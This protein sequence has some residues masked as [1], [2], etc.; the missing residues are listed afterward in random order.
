L[1]FEVD[2]HC[3]TIAS[4]HAY[5]TVLEYVQIAAEKGLKMIAITDH[6][7]AMN[8]APHRYYFGNIKVIPRKIRE[9]YI[10]RGV[11]ANIM[12]FNGSLDLT[13][14]YLNNLDIV[15]AGFHA[16]CFQSGSVEDNTRAAISAIKNPYVDIIVHPGNPEFPIN[17]E[18]VVEAAKENNV[19]IE[20][21]NSSFNLSRKGSAENCLL[22]AKKAAELGAT[23]SLGSDSHICFDVGNFTKA[24]EIIK[25]AGIRQENILNTSVDKVVNFLKSKGRDIV[26]DIKRETKL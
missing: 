18:K 7:P 16:N 12:D 1:I 10:L 13:E 2:T 21:N 14:Y 6:G 22:I 11:E 23:I 4:G 24:R 26:P 20:I 9:V 8:G 19:C 15:L 3:H 5:S 25:I 17:I